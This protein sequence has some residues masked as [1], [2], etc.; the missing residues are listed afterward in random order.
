MNVAFAEAARKASNTVRSVD[1]GAI[2]GLVGC[3]APSA[4]GGYDYWL[5]SQ[6]IDVAEPYNIGCNREIWRSFVPRKPAITTGFGADNMEVWRLWYQALHGDRGVILYDEENRYLEASGHPTALGSRVAPTYRELTGGIV[7]QL[8]TMERVNDPIA[9]HY[10][11]PSLTAHWMSEHRSLGKAW[12]DKHSWHEYTESDFLHLRQS[13]LYLLEDNLQQYYFVSYAQ[14]ENGAFDH[15][16]AKVM[17]LPQSVAMSKEECAVLRRFVERGGWLIADCRTALMDSHSKLQA[18]GQLDDFFGVERADLRFAPGPSGL[19][20][21]GKEKNPLLPSRVENVSTAE[22]GIKVSPDAM[23]FYRDAKGTPA[24]IVNKHGKGASIYLNAFIRDY[25]L[26]QV[27]PRKGETLRQLMAAL[28]RDA[29]VPRQYT[30][31]QSNG[32]PVTSV[33]LHPWQCGNLRLLGIHRNYGLMVS[34]LGPADYQKQTGLTGPL[35]LKIDFEKEV[36]L[37]DSR[38]G[39]FL[40]R[41]K[42]HLFRLDQ[43]QPSIFAILPVPVEALTIDAPSQMSP[44]GLLELKLS[45]NGPTLGDYHAFRVQLLDPNGKELAMLTRNL[46]APRGKAAWDL[47]LAVSVPTGTYTLKVRDVATGIRAEHYLTV[48]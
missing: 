20:Y 48:R 35:E 3:Q 25:H 33:E 18:K 10:S 32:R 46:A 47:P 24:V 7:K 28:L 39:V 17:I 15:M 26:W 16:K 23:A 11:H 9:V 13:T 27:Q 38:Q 31:T 21:V 30:I 6:A 19:D 41:K 37:Y 44:G 42:T 22:P 1:P 2:A 34:E 45:L 43:I 4:F 29:G 40:G 14:L 36:G 8:C 12:V 5:L